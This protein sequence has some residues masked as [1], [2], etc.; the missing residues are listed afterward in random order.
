M[1]PDAR[2]NGYALL[3][4]LLIAFVLS[5]FLSL[6]FTANHYLHRHNLKHAQRLQ[7][8]ADRLEHLYSAPAAD[9]NGER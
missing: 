7:Q 2:R 9:L 4:V 1:K 5:V 8:R 3:L 6:V